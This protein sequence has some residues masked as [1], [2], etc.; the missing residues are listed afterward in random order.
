MDI[1]EKLKKRDEFLKTI[2]KKAYE[3]LR[4]AP[5]QT[6]FKMPYIGVQVNQ[7]DEKLDKSEISGYLL[8]ESIGIDRKTTQE[9]VEFFVKKKPKLLQGLSGNQLFAITQ[10][11]IEYVE[12][13][14]RMSNTPIL[15]QVNVVN[16]TGTQI[17]QN[18]N[19]SNQSLD[20]DIFI[21]AIKDEI[22]QEDFNE[23]SEIIKSKESGSTKKNKIIQK[24]KDFGENVASNI[25]ASLL[26]NPN[27]WGLF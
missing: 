10:E 21:S 5:T 17:Q 7:K 12:N 22:S 24:T 6:Y 26:T 14:E 8:G 23:L 19:N 25:I 11:G 2:Y 27:I 16:S 3:E 9:F 1:K 18:T 15:S 4:N 13:L 20:I